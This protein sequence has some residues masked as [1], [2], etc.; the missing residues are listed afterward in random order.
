LHAG[1]V[2]G[3]YD[4]IRYKVCIWI[5]IFFVSLIILVKKKRLLNN[6]IG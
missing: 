5:P 1:A 6:W 2:Y 3:T 4:A